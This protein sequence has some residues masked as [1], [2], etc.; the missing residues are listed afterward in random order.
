VMQIVGDRVVIR[1]I[2]KEDLTSLL[3]WCNDPEVMYYAND[4]PAPHKTLQELEEEFAK[5]KGEWSAS[6]ETFVI[7]TR[8]GTL[9]GDIMY[10]W[11]RPD[12]RSVYIG[13]L[14]GEK[15]YWG[16][17]YGTEAIKLFLRYLFIEKQLH[18]VAVTVSDFNK[19]AIRVYEKCGFRKDG[20]LRDNAIIDDE[21]VDH[22]VM[23]ILEDEYKQQVG[24]G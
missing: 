17:G 11:Y 4:D 7:E 16:H 21:F 23:S 2:E 8:D 22:I 18:K 14:I 13:V 6:M 9:I 3:S 15:E 10:R 12:I 24:S 1:P 19:R 20:I 5:Q